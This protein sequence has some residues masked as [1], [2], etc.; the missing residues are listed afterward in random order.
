MADIEN[1]NDDTINNDD[2]LQE[3][4]LNEDED[5]IN[6]TAL[7]IESGPGESVEF[8]DDTLKWIWREIDML[9]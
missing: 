3:I 7:E 5:V 6:T 1:Q 8:N 4:E 2:S 9:N